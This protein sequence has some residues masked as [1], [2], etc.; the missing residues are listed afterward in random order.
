LSNQSI[1]N[2][3]VTK[4]LINQGK[5]LVLQFSLGEDSTVEEKT[6]YNIDS[7]WIVLCEQDHRVKNQREEPSMQ[8]KT[9]EI[10]QLVEISHDKDE[11][12]KTSEDEP[13]EDNND[14]KKSRI[15][16]KKEKE[17]KKK[18]SGRKYKYFVDK[19]LQDYEKITTAINL[20]QQDN[21][22]IQN[23]ILENNEE[24]LD[25]QEDSDNV[26]KEDHSIEESEEELVLN[27]LN[28]SQK[29]NEDKN[30]PEEFVFN[31]NMFDLTMED[32]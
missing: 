25:F 30:D 10:Q 5:F 1:L 2:D 12:Y 11:K 22:K 21:I 18:S 28:S 13:I 15:E 24:F 16:E 26:E 9:Q 27:F 32:D 17:V 31:D 6:N 14:C 4:T 8:P 20:L 7:I 23:I 19:V 29:N 3:Q